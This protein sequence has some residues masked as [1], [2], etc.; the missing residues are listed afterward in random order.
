MVS[1]AEIHLLLTLLF[2]QRISTATKVGK[3][4]PPPQ[5]NDFQYLLKCNT[6]ATLI[7]H[8]GLGRTQLSSS[9]L[10]SILSK[11]RDVHPP[12][13]MGEFLRY[14]MA[15][16]NRQNCIDNPV[17]HKTQFIRMTPPKV[18]P[19]CYMYSITSFP[20][21]DTISGAHMFCTNQPTQKDLLFGDTCLHV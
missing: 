9:A 3:T 13:N 21:S 11:V 8:I 16:I 15:R 5:E 18:I 7:L 14:I 19:L 1:K 2:K 4:L 6:N 20:G 17:L 10:E 12:K